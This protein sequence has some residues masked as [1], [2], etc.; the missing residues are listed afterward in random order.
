MRP[1]TVSKLLAAIPEHDRRRFIIR[2]FRQNEDAFAEAL[3][4]MAGLSSWDEA[5]RVIDQIYAQNQIDPFSY[6]AERFSGVL[7]QH[8]HRTT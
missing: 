5:S 2:I 4:T 1:T 6:D 7:F 8:Y 3:E